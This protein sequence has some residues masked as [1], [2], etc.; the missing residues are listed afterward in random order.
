MKSFIQSRSAG[1]GERPLLA[2]DGLAHLEQ[3]A[4]L[5]ERLRVGAVERVLL[6]AAHQEVVQHRPAAAGAHLAR[7]ETARGPGRARSR[8][9]RP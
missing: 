1:A 3:P 9:A 8:A 2:L 5:R 7:S 4:V 6:E